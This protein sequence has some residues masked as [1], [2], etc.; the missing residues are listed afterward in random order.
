M[1]DV[2]AMSATDEMKKT[3]VEWFSIIPGME[4]ASSVPVVKAEGLS[5]REFIMN[6]VSKNR[7]CLIKGAVKNWPASQKWKNK[8]YWITTCKNEKKDIATRMNYFSWKRKKEGRESVPFHDAI[9]RLFEGRD[10][11]FSMPSQLVTEN[12][13]FSGIIKDLPGFP[14]LQKKKAPL[15]DSARVVYIYRSAST[16]WHVHNCDETL[17]SQVKGTKQVALLP[18]TMPHAKYVTNFMEKE[19]YL[20]GEVLDPSWDLKPV[21]VNVEEGDTLYIPPHWFHC[22]VPKDGEIGFTFITGFRSPWHVYGNFSNYFVRR[23]YKRVMR[24]SSIPLRIGAPFLGV[25]AGLSR[26]VKKITGRGW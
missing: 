4:K 16:A 9:E 6:W 23:L 22:V 17:M 2:L 5:Q 7:P 8:D 19:M 1:E 10:H 13:L 11:V 12:N 26:L 15:W 25:Y 3:A 14:F 20:E 24:E 18:A 21:V